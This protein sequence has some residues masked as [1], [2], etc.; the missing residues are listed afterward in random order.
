MRFQ[1]RIIFLFIHMHWINPKAYS[2]KNEPQ[3]QVFCETIPTDLSCIE[4]YAIA[5]LPD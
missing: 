5:K 2:R 4:I 3:E 1:N